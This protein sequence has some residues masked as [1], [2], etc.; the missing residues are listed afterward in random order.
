MQYIIVMTIPDQTLTRFY[1]DAAYDWRRRWSTTTHPFHSTKTED[2]SIL[3]Q[4][5]QRNL[6]EKSRAFMDHHGFS[7]IEVSHEDFLDYETSELS[8]RDWLKEYCKSKKISVKADFLIV[9]PRVK[10]QKSS[11][12]KTSTGATAPHQVKDYLGIM[13]VALKQTNNIK[14]KSSIDTIAKAMK[15]IEANEET[16]AIKNHYW[17]PHPTTKFRGHKSLWLAKPTESD[18]F[19]DEY[20]QILAEVK[21]EHESQMDIDKLTRK[22]INISRSATEAQARFNN[23]GGT[24]KRAT[25]NSRAERDKAESITAIGQI[26]YDRVFTDANLTVFM[27]PQLRGTNPALPLTAILVA[28]KETVEEH[29]PSANAKHLIETISKMDMFSKIKKPSKKPTAEKS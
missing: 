14:N 6:S 19:N 7:Y 17:K 23:L 28:V 3:A 16:L 5:S 20:Y 2:Y 18:D 10:T 25:L 15:A 22:F 4:E 1:R 27:D 8:F 29:F 11:D 12:R 13:F 9:G 24:P 21:I 26:L